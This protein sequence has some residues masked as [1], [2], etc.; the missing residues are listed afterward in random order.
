[1]LCINICGLIPL[2]KTQ[3]AG[4]VELGAAGDIT[5]SDSGRVETTQLAYDKD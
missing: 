3:G 2:K 4:P 1:M 5:Q